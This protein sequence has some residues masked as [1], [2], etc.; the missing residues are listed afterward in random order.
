MSRS[1]TDSLPTRRSLLT[2]LRSWE[3]RQGWQEF[4]DAYYGLILS[5]VRKAGLRGADADEVAQETLVAVSKE[6]KDFRYDSS[7]GS[8][9]G[10]LKTVVTRRVVDYFR[11]QERRQACLRKFADGQDPDMHPGALSE[12]DAYY[13]QEWE[14]HLR[15]Q[16]LSWL[17]GRLSPRQYT[18]FD[19]CV[20]Q[21]NPAAE[22][23]RLMGVNRGAVYM[24]KHR[25]ERLLRRRMKDLTEGRPD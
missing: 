1:T 13:E 21:G 24:A 25:A 23:A 3:D 22:V 11:K 10:W 17:K 4:Y 18:M 20:V 16:A 14:S 19:L 7:R 2:R 6:M 9:K 12:M 5:M 8:F 15:A